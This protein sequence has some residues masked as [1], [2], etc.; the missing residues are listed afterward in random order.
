MRWVIPSCP[1]FKK[2]TSLYI[3]AVIITSALPLLKGIW[4]TF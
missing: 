2:I 3:K 4:G 1:P